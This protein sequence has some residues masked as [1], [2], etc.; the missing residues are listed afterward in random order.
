MFSLCCP[1]CCDR[2]SVA[3]VFGV[4]AMTLDIDDRPL[5]FAFVLSVAQLGAEAMAVRWQA[6]ASS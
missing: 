4:K 2:P 1:A 6:N 5:P 3:A